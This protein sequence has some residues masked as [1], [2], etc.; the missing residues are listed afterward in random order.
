MTS[1]VSLSMEKLGASLRLAIIHRSDRLIA[2]AA[3]FKR[4]EKRNLASHN[5][6]RVRAICC[7]GRKGE[8]MFEAVEVGHKLGKQEYEARELSLRTAL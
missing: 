3:A 1:S 6:A 4:V 5:G 8:T 7:G 2:V